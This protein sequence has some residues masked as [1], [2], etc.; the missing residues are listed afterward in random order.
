MRTAIVML[1]LGVPDETTVG[2]AR[3]LAAEVERRAVQPKPD[4]VDFAL[5]DD[6]PIGR[7]AGVELVDPLDAE[8]GEPRTT[9][10]TAT[11]T[12]LATMGF[13][14]NDQSRDDA[15]E[16]W[17]AVTIVATMSEHH[18]VDGHG[19]TALVGG[20][21]TTQIASSLPDAVPPPLVN[22]LGVSAGLSGVVEWGRGKGVDVRG[23]VA[24]ILGGQ[25]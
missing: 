11:S 7:C 16:H 25:G 8:A 17:V 15:P 2:E 23:H 21:S 14:L 19:T 22:E 6:R 10:D 20:K 12:A 18:D 13:V 5:D 1:E 3:R 4:T 9:L 24:Q